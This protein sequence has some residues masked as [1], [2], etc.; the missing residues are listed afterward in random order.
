MPK[1]RRGGRGGI[2]ARGRGTRGRHRGK[3]N[4]I[5]DRNQAYDAR[6]IEQ[7]ELGQQDLQPE[8]D[9]EVGEQDEIN[10]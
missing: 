2:C 5:A 7:E 4:E 6:W 1:L 3:H 10:Q 8:V 9:N